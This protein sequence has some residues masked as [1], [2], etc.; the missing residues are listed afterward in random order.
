MLDIDTTEKYWLAGLLEGEGSFVKGSPSNPS[1]SA[2]SL[3]MTDEDIISK[4]SNIFGV[5]YHKCKKQKSHHKHSYALHKRGSGAVEIMKEL[6]PLMGKRRQ[7]QIHDAITSYYKYK[8]NRINKLSNYDV[9][10]IRKRLKNRETHG[11]IALLYNVDRTTISHIKSGRL[12]PN[13]M[14]DIV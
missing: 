3:Q 10:D 12:F 14:V 8:N 1:Q 13:I 7:E 2:I 11:D 9:I 5:K 4:V 6:L